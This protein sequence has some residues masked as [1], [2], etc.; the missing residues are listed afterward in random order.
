MSDAAHSAI[1]ALFPDTPCPALAGARHWLRMLGPL[2]ADALLLVS[3]E[4]RPLAIADDGA[5]FDAEGARRMARSA[6]RALQRRG[7]PGAKTRFA[8]SRAQPPRPLLVAALGPLADGAL[9]VCLCREAVCPNRTA[10]ARLRTVGRL[11]WQLHQAGHER[12]RLLVQA[13]HL[14]A[15][16]DTLRHSYAEA[17][18]AAIQAHDE[19]LRQERDSSARIQAVMRTAPDGIL[20]LDEWGRVVAMNEAVTRIFGFQPEEA[21]GREIFDI[22]LPPRARQRWRSALARFRQLDFH[23]WPDRTFELRTFRIDGSALHLEVS[24]SAV[25]LDDRWHAVVSLHDIT[26]RKRTERELAHY[27]DHLETLVS[28]RTAELAQ[29]NVQLRQVCQ[30]AQAANQAKSRFL[31]GVS[32]EI[33]TPLNSII[34]FTEVTLTENLS[35]GTRSHLDTVLRESQHLLTLINDLLDMAKIEAGKLELERRAVDLAAL[36]RAVIGAHGVHARRKGIGLELLVAERVPQ[37]IEGDEIRLRQ[38]LMNLLSNAVKFTAEGSVRLRVTPLERWNQE[39]LLKWEVIDTGIGIPQDRQQAIFDSFTQA[40]S[41]TTRRYGGTG[42]GTTIARQLVELMGGEIGLESEPGKGST[43]W[44]TLRAR[45]VARDGAG[46]PSP[47]APPDSAAPVASADI[48]VVDDYPPNRQLIALHLA[49]TGH[50]VAMATDGREAL[51][52]CRRQKFDLVLMDLQ[53]PEMDGLEATRQIRTTLE[54]YRG[55]PILGVTADASP[56]TIVACTDAGMDDV[57]VKPIR[58]KSFLATIQSAL[59]RR[60][61]GRGQAKSGGRRSHAAGPEGRT[62]GEPCVERTAGESTATADRPP[63]DWGVGAEE[64][65]D[66]KLYETVVRQFAGNLP[67]RVAVLRDALAAADVEHLRAEAHRLRGGAAN[68][69]AQPLAEAGRE[70][71]HAAK[72]GC[73]DDMPRLVGR[74]AEEAERLVA[75][76]GGS[77]AG[78]PVM[79]S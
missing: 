67:S 47:A 64:F 28:E 39:V 52:A 26:Q 9:A 1:E 51:E 54:P 42:L 34:G 7:R 60:S 30:A 71:E 68:L 36:H 76:I 61:T 78:S 11:A 72:A 73:L 6:R 13:Q 55:V 38:V 5:P 21:V 22:A 59:C 31:A 17:H 19:R 25:E 33:R 20:T 12:D 29:A 2:K 15:E 77:P 75:F 48:L 32:H 16:H 79:S 58:R 62:G 41:G 57:L 35:A 74:F 56:D 46:A 50:R 69:W 49:E 70:I 23:D 27:R 8:A 18:V 24:L 40:D 14:R 43:F 45:R 65:G 66:R 37:W 63:L 44:F 4:G 53:M 3:P 10:L